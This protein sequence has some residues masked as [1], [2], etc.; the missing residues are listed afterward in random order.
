MA[1]SAE[2]SRPSPLRIVDHQVFRQRLES[3][4]RWLWTAGGPAV[5]FAAPS[6]ELLARRVIE[7]SDLYTVDRHLLGGGGPRGG[8]LL[9]KLFYFLCSDAPKVHLVLSELS[10]RGEW[11]EVDPTA[12]GRQGRVVDLGCG[13]GASSVGFLLSVAPRHE[14]SA[15]VPIL[16]RGVDCDPTVLDIWRTVIEF[17]AGLAGVSADTAVEHA[18]LRTIDLHPEDSLVICQGALNECLATCGEVGSQSFDAPF[19]RRIASWAR[20]RAVML[21]EP[22]LRVT[23]RPLHLLRDAVLELAASELNL[24]KLGDDRSGGG[25]APV[26]V[27]APCPHHARCP[28]LASTRDWCHEVRLWAPT[29]GVA[30]VQALTKRRDDRVKFSFAVLGPG[31]DPSAGSHRADARLVSDPLPSKGKVERYACTAEGTLRHLR[32]LDRERTD[33]NEALVSLRR[34]AL[35]SI[36]GLGDVDR[37]AAQVRVR[38]L[39]SGS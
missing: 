13:V 29:P 32:I 20:E 8:L 33:A 9:A 16:L 37:V 26:R 4:E 30:T 15:R 3:L 21:I 38:A 19:V 11:D 35:V 36:E 24:T 6:A 28:M 12:P 14:A 22:A 23:T 25:A 18:N 27:L 2:R 5:G 1:P 10:A 34:G 39:D 17:A 31:R 7:L